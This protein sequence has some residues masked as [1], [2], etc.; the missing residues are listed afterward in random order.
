[1]SRGSGCHGG[2]I[3]IEGGASIGDLAIGTGTYFFQLRA[4]GAEVRLIALECLAGALQIRAR[5][6]EF[7][8]RML[9]F[10]LYASDLFLTAL[11]RCPNALEF[12]MGVLP[13]F[14]CALELLLTALKRRPGTLELG[15]CVLQ[16]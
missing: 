6:L 10:F 7:V 3:G 15:E 5:R 8:L 13:P 4:R 16:L 2:A 14:L 1:L 11:K 12:I 9:T